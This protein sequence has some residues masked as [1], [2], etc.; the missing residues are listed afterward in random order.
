MPARGADEGIGLMFDLED[1]RKVQSSIKWLE[2][3]LRQA[4]RRSMTDHGK[5]VL[6]AFA[7]NVPKMMFVFL[8][9][10]ALVMRPLYWRPRRYYV[11][12]LVFFLHTHAALFLI[13]LLEMP[14]S[15]LAAAVPAVRRP[16]EVVELAGLAYAGWYIFRALRVYYGQSRRRTFAKL[17]VVSVAYLLFLSITLLAT[18]LASALTA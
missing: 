16:V 17:A 7:A 18:L 9:L 15:W 1:C 13:L 4:C 5:S 8:P 14:L 2:E 6:H 11:E 3:P 12:H 10:M